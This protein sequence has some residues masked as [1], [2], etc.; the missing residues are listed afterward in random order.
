MQPSRKPPMT[1]CVFRFSFSSDVP[2]EE[3]EMTLQLATFAVEGLFGM[4]RLRIDF[5]YHVDS[6]RRT[7]LVDGTT[8]VGAVVVQVFTG[9]L[10]REFGEDAFRMA[11]MQSHQPQPK[12]TA[13]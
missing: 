11:P 12:E 2:L 1:A 4:A 9:L 5:S 3:A 13:A 6:A 10:L 7:I 8:E